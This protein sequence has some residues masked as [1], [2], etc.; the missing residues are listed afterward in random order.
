MCPQ[1]EC[2]DY[3]SLRVLYHRKH[4]KVSAKPLSTVVELEDAD[5]EA[6][7]REWADLVLSDADE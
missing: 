3:F 2:P 1:L 5:V 6:A 4:A 7:K